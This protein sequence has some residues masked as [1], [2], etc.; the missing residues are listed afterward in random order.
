MNC[1]IC[2]KPGLPDFTSKPVICPQCNS[3]LKGFALLEQTISIH[4]K[5]VKK[6]KDKYTA[7][8]EQTNSAHKKTVKKQKYIYTLLL[9]IVVLGFSVIVFFPSNTATELPPIVQNND[10]IID[11]LEAKLEVKELEINR[12]QSLLVEPK[13]TS[14]LYIVKS[15][16]NLSKIALL[17]YNNW[18][19]YKKIEEDNNLERGDLLFPSDTL[20]INL[21]SHL[22][23]D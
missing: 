10:S 6:Q 20:L 23:K 4:N 9:A 14:F 18:E 22:W 5:T 1:P 3:D 2:N 7:I 11:V 21:K 15:G 13:E 17:F 16:D 8:L 19:M 12:L